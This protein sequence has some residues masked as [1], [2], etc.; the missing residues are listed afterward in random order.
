[1]EEYKRPTFTVELDEYKDKYAIGDTIKIKGHAK[2]YSG[3][4]VQGAKVAYNVN[5][6]YVWWWRSYNDDEIVHE[7]N[8]VT[9]EK[10]DFEVVVPFIFPYN[11]KGTKDETLFFNFEIEADVT[12]V[13]GESRSA[14]RSLPLGTKATLLT[15]NMPEKVLKDSL[16]QVKFNY[17]NAAGQPIEGKVCYAIAPFKNGKATFGKYLTVETNKDID[18]KPL[19]SGHY[20]LQA[21]CGTDTLEHEFVVFS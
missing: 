18:L 21:I 2:T 4:P 19:S 10:G 20:K 5:R 7:D 11:E 15:S 8:V 17:L 12:D 9:D 1:M 14:N 13:A 6:R 16:R 3:M